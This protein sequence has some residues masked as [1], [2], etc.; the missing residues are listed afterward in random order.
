MIFARV[1]KG[2]SKRAPKSYSTGLHPIVP[3][4]S[5]PVQGLLQRKETHCACGGGC[6]RCQSKLAIQTKLAIS[7]PGD[8]YEQEADRVA[9]Q[10]L[11]SASINQQH[12]SEKSG[13]E[14][15]K[16]QVV[17]QTA[18]LAIKPLVQRQDDENIE[19]QED[20]QQPS[21]AGELPSTAKESTTLAVVKGFPINDSFCGCDVAIEKEIAFVKIMIRIFTSCNREV[22]K[23]N[24]AS[25]AVNCKKRKLDQMGIKT[26]QVGHVDFKRNKEV[27]E[28]PG[29]CG[30]ILTH[31][32]DLH[33][34]K[35][36]VFKGFKKMELGEEINVT[37]HEYSKSE[38][39]G[40]KKELSFLKAVL[41]KLK[42][43]C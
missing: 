4:A 36:Y 40:Y 43:Q 18:P 19:Q 10:V 30:P 39:K 38:I 35:H 20:T 11:R 8:K 33:E 31:S 15:L 34:S 1:Q 6:P 42:K 29:V 12:F 5:S 2:D 17:I 9:D 16:D 3:V 26:K 14:S 22:P 32:Y 37:A 25:E 23:N 13:E 7:R 24:N 27:Q 28:Q 41:R 21:S